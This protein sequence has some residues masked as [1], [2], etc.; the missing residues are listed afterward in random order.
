MNFFLKSIIFLS[1]WIC[2]SYCLASTR[3]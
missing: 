2:Y 1:I 3:M